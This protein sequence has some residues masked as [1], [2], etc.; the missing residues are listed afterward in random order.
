MPFEPIW[1]TEPLV[2]EEDGVLH[3][4]DWKGLLLFE[5]GCF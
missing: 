2:G 3:G 1:T 5:E 4:I